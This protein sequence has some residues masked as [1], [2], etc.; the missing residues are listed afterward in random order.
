MNYNPFIAENIIK[1]A[2]SE[3]Q[4][5]MIMDE[6]TCISCGSNKL[7]VIQ[8]SELEKEQCKVDMFPVKCLQCG[9][10]FII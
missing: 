6:N 4:V 9:K 1:Q 7:H 10:L 3:E 2:L 8:L 5:K